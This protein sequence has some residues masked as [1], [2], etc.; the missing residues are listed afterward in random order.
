M[1]ADRFVRMS[2][3]NNT[4][5]RSTTS[6]QSASEPIIASS[7]DEKTDFGEL[8][9]SNAAFESLRSAESASEYARANRPN[10]PLPEGESVPTMAQLWAYAHRRYARFQGYAWGG[11]VIVGAAAWGASRVLGAEDRKKT[12]AK[13]RT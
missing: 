11:V 13:M 8:P 5:T 10:A 1:R 2:K 6:G 4:E 9:M 3:D 7:P 12:H